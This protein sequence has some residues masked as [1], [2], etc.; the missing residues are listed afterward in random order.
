MVIGSKPAF[1]SPLQVLKGSFKKDFFLNLSMNA[2]QFL[3][4]KQASK[5]DRIL[6]SNLFFENFFHFLKFF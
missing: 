5:R 4:S 6:T 3:M 2:S 1:S